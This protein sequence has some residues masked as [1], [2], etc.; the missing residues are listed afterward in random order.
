MRSARKTAPTPRWAALVQTTMESSSRE[1]ATE[2]G[3]LDDFIAK[4]AMGVD[5]V[6]H[7]ARTTRARLGR[8]HAEAVAALA[9]TPVAADAETAMGAPGAPQHFDTIR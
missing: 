5:H 4:A 6:R 7:A 9:P 8:L 3:R 1:E 2:T